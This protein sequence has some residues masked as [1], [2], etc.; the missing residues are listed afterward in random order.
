M[1]KRGNA[2]VKSMLK[3]YKLEGQYNEHLKYNE[4]KME[5]EEDESENMEESKGANIA[6]QVNCKG[7]EINGI[8][9]IALMARMELY[10]NEIRWRG[11]SQSI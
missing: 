8:N 10:A 3:V 2:S 7:G 5:S 11:A 9:T 1:I 6:E 4:D